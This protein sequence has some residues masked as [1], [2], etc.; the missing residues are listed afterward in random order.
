M[1]F[2]PKVSVLLLVAVTLLFSA[3]GP[4]YVVQPN[5]QAA[6]YQPG[7][8]PNQFAYDAA[9]AIA[10]VNGVNGYYGPNHVFYPSVM[11]GG[12]PGYYVG[13]VFHTS[14]SNRTVVINNYQNDVRTHQS[15]ANTGKPNYN[16]P[17]GSTGKPDYTTKS[18]GPGVIQRGS[19]STATPVAAQTPA[20]KPAYSANP[21]TIG[22]G[23]ASAPPA[24]LP[25][26]PS[27]GG[28]GGIQ[29]SVSAPPAAASRPAYSNG[30]G[31]GRK[32]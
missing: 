13:G 30:G 3:C 6:A 16:A 4:T 22:R 27:Y 29:R 24:A 1:S 12:V 23:A 19:P 15:Q 14:Q 11:L 10:V 5:G 9:L 26:K 18:G 7:Y 21:G 32:R 2:T 25:S 8:D 31:I 20:G 17:A 28:G